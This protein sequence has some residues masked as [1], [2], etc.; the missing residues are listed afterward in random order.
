ME[1]RIYFRTKF[2]PLTQQVH[3]INLRYP[4]VFSYNLRKDK[5]ECTGEVQ[6]SLLSEKYKIRVIY[7]LQSMP[8]VYVLLPTLRN[9]E[10]ESIPHIYPDG[11]LC[12]FLPGEWTKQAY[13]ADTV[14]PWA[15]L[16]LYYY[17]MW[18]ATG[19]WLGGGSHPMNN[20]KKMEKK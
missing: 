9:R 10:L 8:H 14:I 3:R 7:S 18:H 13:L 11:H 16:W 17:E 20:K 1:N 6:P 5:L 15:I 4:G 12:L 19:E 2:T